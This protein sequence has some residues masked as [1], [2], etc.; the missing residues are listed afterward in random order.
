[1]QDCS[2]AASHQGLTWCPAKDKPNARVL[3]EKPNILEEKVIWLQ[4]HDKDCSGL[5]GMLPLAKGMPVALTDH[6]DRNPQKNLLR[7]RIGYID[8]WVVPD[9]DHG[10]FSDGIRIL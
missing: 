4:T 3:N 8:S 10:V 1:M 7:G 6:V 9:D 2:G 5:Y